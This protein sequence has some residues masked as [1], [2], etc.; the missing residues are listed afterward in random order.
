MRNAVLALI[1]AIAAP[2]HLQPAAAQPRPAGGPAVQDVAGGRDHPLVGRYDGSRIIRYEQREFAEVLLATRALRRADGTRLA[3]DGA[4]P[5]EGRH[6]RLTYQGPA[7]RSALEVIRNFQERLRGTGF[8]LVFECAGGACAEGNAADR[9][10]AA[11]AGD[12]GMSTQFMDRV[13]HAVFRRAAPQ[14]DAWVSL[15]VTEFGGTAT[16]PQVQPQAYIQ[17]VEVRP[18][19]TGQIVFVDAAAMQRSIDQTGRVALYGILFDFDRADI[20]PES[21]PTLE[22]IAR[23]LRANPTVNL[24]VAGHTDNQGAFDYNVALSQRRAASVVQTL[25]RDFAIAAAR[26]TPFGAGMAAPVAPN[27]NEEGRQRNRRVELVRR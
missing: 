4:T 5:V 17:V 6:T 7:G 10:F 20:R 24:V 2:W 25:T 9:F 21:R 12:S 11:V 13:R 26:L 22:E 8:E 27:D 1:V 14:G 15:T 18:M 16:N 3:R 23:Y 19:Q